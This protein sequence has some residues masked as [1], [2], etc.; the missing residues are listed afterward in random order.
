MKTI[1]SLLLALVLFVL[2]AWLVWEASAWLYARNAWLIEQT[3][4][5][6][7]LHL[8]ARILQSLLLLAEIS[9]LL[10]I[11]AA[12]LIRYRRTR[13]FVSFKHIH[14][15]KAREIARSIE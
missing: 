13:V 14:E 4:G 8:G 9:I 11:V 3:L 5:L 12:S 10:L 6:P 1:L 15:A 2:G 7:S